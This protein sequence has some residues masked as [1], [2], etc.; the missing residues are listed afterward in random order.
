M[1]FALFLNLV[2]GGVTSA[3]FGKNDKTIWQ[4]GNTFQ[5][6][7]ESLTFLNF[8]LYI[9]NIFSCTNFYRA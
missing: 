1:N 2:V 7:K 6:K 3:F 5:E 4:C 8:V 9:K